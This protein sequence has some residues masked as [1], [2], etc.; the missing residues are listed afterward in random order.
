MWVFFTLAVCMS[1]ITYLA[2]GNYSIWDNILNTTDLVLT[3]TVSVAIALFGDRTS[4]F[5]TFDKGCLVAVVGIMFFWLVTR[6]HL[7]TNLAVQS[8]LVIAYLPVIKRLFESKS[9]TEPF[10]VWILMLIAPV[11][12]LLSSQG[13]MASIYSWRAICCVALLLI[14]MLRVEMISG[15]LKKSNVVVGD[16]LHEKTAT[17]NRDGGYREG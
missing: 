5:T 14:L 10:S 11:F 12:A 2:D 1:L 9:N 6:N 3:L 15:G 4:R 17:E 16:E 7:A 8:I 13:L